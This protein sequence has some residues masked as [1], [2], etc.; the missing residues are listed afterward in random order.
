VLAPGG[1]VF[2][3]EGTR[4]SHFSDLVFGG[5]AG[6][7]SASGTKTSTS[8]ALT[9]AAWC[10]LL[11]ARGFD[12]VA[13]VPPAESDPGMAII[14]AHAA[15]E[16]LAR[17]GRQLIFAD[18][19][20]LGR[21]LAHRFAETGIASTL[22]RPGKNYVRLKNGNVRI[23]PASG[24]DFRRLLEETGGDGAIEGAVM[25]WG[26]DALAAGTRSIDAL[27]VIQARI[28][29]AA[30]HLAALLPRD[31]ECGRN[32]EKAIDLWL[33]TRQAGGGE[34]DENPRVDSRGP[35]G[36]VQQAM[37]RSAERAL[38]AGV[39]QRHLDLPAVAAAG[40]ARLL[41]ATVMH[42]PG[43]AVPVV[44]RPAATATPQ[45]ACLPP[46]NPEETAV[47][48]ILQRLLGLETIGRDDDFFEMGGD[49]LIGIQLL[50]QLRQTFQLDAAAAD[51]PVLGDLLKFRTA[52]DLARLVR[53]R[54]P[55]HSPLIAMTRASQGNPLFLV[56]PGGGNVLCYE[57]L[58]RHLATVPI[59][60]IQAPG[61]RDEEQ[62]L[63]DIAA[64]A[65]NYLAAVRRLRPR[66]PYRL[67]G[68]CSGCLVAYEMARQI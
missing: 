64:M 36:L 10:R 47:I 23:D 52:A 61:L 13:S 58:S 6:W 51:T 57:A 48:A 46:R 9:A 12:R 54:K 31:S 67:A 4:R 3:L 40:E 35:R 22:I 41:A 26:L 43:A 34:A 28:T 30:E 63:D 62:P 44:T 2:L 39:S 25:L 59:Y 38:A 11:A 32:G 27:A 18:A 5:L 1:L 49:S 33:V 8:P 53:Q 45:E 29:R 65:A 14:M 50:S 16:P 19:G 24:D 20:G 17:N 21:E 42:P 7:T 15:A 56:H 68:W 55:R 60:A 66:G 37:V